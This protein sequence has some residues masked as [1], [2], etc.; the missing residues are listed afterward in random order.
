MAFIARSGSPALM[1][2]TILAC[3]AT[4]LSRCGSLRHIEKSNPIH[5]RLHVLDHF[6]R[7]GSADAFGEKPM[8]LLVQGEEFGGGLGAQRSFLASQAV[9]EPRQHG[10]RGFQRRFPHHGAL[11]RLPDEARIL[12]GRGRDLDDERPALWQDPYEA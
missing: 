6:P 11:D 4:I 5:L 9:C 1:A 10:R 12:D 3:C 7:G 8:K 2:S